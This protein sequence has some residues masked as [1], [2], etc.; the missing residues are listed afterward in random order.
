[1][2]IRRDRRKRREETRRL[3][4]SN[5]VGTIV[6]DGTEARVDRLPRLGAV[7]ATKLDG[8]WLISE[9]VA[10]SEAD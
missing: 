7:E 5:G 3:R 6:V 1:M 4:S 9:L 2:G 10:L 8:Q